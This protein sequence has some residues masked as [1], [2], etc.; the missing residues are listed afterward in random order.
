[1]DR[2]SLRPASTFNDWRMR[3]GTRRLLTTTWPRL[4]SVGA[5][6][7]ASKA[8]SQIE[9]SSNSKAAVTVPRMI[10]KGIPIPSNRSGIT[11]SFSSFLSSA[12][13]AS[14]NS[15]RARVSSA[16]SRIVSLRTSTS[17]TLGRATN[18]P[19]PARVKRIG[20]VRT[21]LSIRFEISIKKK[22]RI[23]KIAMMSMG[24]LAYVTRVL[25]RAGYPEISER[26]ALQ[27]KSINYRHTHLLKFVHINQFFER[28][29]QGD[30]LPD[31]FF[32]S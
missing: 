9:I 1:M 16:I 23:T 10:V 14:V 15:S 20:A 12:R 21:V 25:I 22:T 18:T 28:L 30:L 3:C 6:I 11:N 29:F 27:L 5:R 32:W 2:P 26:I 7:T 13:E 31:Q 4:A 24:H 17:A 19:I 8:A